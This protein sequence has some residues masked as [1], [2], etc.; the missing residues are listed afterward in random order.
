MHSDLRTTCDIREFLVHSYL[1]LQQHT[2]ILNTIKCKVKVIAQTS[3]TVSSHLP[4]TSDFEFLVV[5]GLPS[6]KKTFPGKVCICTL[7]L[8]DSSISPGWL[9]AAHVQCSAETVNT[10]S[11]TASHYNTHIDKTTLDFMK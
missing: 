6:S 3:D 4:D 1:I 9:F 5:T 11:F 7:Q 10:L 2:K 8:V